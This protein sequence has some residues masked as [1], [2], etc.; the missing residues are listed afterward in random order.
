MWEKWGGVIK[1][2]ANWALRIDGW[3]AKKRRRLG[4]EGNGHESIYRLLPSLL[5]L[6]GGGEGERIFG[7]T[8]W[9]AAS[10][11][12]CLKKSLPFFSSA[13]SRAPKNDAPSHNKQTRSF[14][15]RKKNTN[16][17]C[18]LSCKGSPLLSLLLSLQNN[19][20]GPPSHT[21]YF[22]TGE[23]EEEENGGAK[24]PSSNFVLDQKMFFAPSTTTHTN[25]PQSNNY[26][27]VQ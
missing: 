19:D 8:S 14:L 24:I 1:E 21:K 20:Y 26:L 7:Q 22:A 10:F 17:N 6:C 5:L 25:F 11:V 23:S 13:D 18:S 27:H 12:S 16:N 15:P 4:W 3:A 9:K 2:W